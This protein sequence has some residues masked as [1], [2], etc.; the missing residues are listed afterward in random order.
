MA[1]KRVYPKRTLIITESLDSYRFV[2]EMY[3]VTPRFLAPEND[4]KYKFAY[5]NI[6]TIELYFSNT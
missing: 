2:S 1:L 5:P 4:P 6:H 3:F